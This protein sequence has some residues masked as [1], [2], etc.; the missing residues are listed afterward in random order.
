MNRKYSIYTTLE[1]QNIADG[2]LSK[3]YLYENQ[4]KV[5]NEQLAMR[6]EFYTTTLEL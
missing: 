5:I 2:F 1:R 3:L 4:R 6:D